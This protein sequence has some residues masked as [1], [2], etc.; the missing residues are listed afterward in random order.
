MRRAWRSAIRTSAFLRKELVETLRQP[1]MIAVLVLAPFLILLL[2]GTGLKDSDP[3]VATVVVV[4]DDDALAAEVERFATEPSWRLQVQKITWDRDEALRQLDRGE[5][6][7]V[8]V[9]PEDAAETV[10]SNRRATVALYHNLVDPIESRALGLA[11]RAAVDRLNQQILHSLV[12]EGQAR[13]EDI[14]ER[15]AQARERIA[16][17]RRAAEAGDEARAQAQ[18][19]RLQDEVRALSL[20]L[21]A[22]RLL[23]APQ[24]GRDDARGAPTVSEAFAA[25]ERGLEELA[26]EARAGREELDDVARDLDRLDRA[27]AEFQSLSPE[28]IVSPFKGSLRRLATVRVGLTDFFAPGVVVLLLQHLLVTLVGL[29]VVHDDQLGTT[30]LFRIAPVTTREVLLG[31]YLS[32]LLLSAAVSALLVALLILGLGVPLAGSVAVLIASV[33][34]VLFTSIGMGFVIALFARTDSQTV[35]YA[36]MVLLASI[37]LTGFLITLDRVVPSLQV[38]AWLLPP[39]YGM[40]L[41]RDVMLRGTGLELRLLLGLFGIGIALLVVSWVLL[42]RRL[43]PAAPDDH[44]RRRRR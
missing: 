24:L 9:F 5:I 22:A 37:F 4:P 28:T 36:M 21:P 32:Y 11:T 1:R 33:A 17:V 6:D 34:A 40:A 39:T 35:Q 2:F 10:R 26:G 38:V 14:D 15:L 8:V 41:L 29:S 30:E 20:Q 3:V 43:E 16:M 7:L 23:D 12:A 42:R 44:G 27:V 25:L 18:L 19:M 13:S 31:K